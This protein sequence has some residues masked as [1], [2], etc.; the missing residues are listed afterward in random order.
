MLETDD[1]K[2]TIIIRVSQDDLSRTALNI[3]EQ[4]LM[5]INKGKGLKIDYS[6]FLFLFLLEKKEIDCVIIWG[7]K[8]KEKNTVECLALDD[9]ELFG[10]KVFSI[11]NQAGAV[12]DRLAINQLITHTLSTKNSSFEIDLSEMGFSKPKKEKS[13]NKYNQKIWADHIRVMSEYEFEN[14]DIG[15]SIYRDAILKWQNTFFASNP[16]AEN[17]VLQL[18]CSQVKPWISTQSTIVQ[19]AKAY[20]NLCE[21]LMLC[22]DYFPE[23]TSSKNLESVSLKMLDKISDYGN[24]SFDLYSYGM[25]AFF[26]VFYQILNRQEFLKE[27]L[28]VANISQNYFEITALIENI[29]GE[30]IYVNQK[31]SLT[32][33]EEIPHIL[34]AD[35][36]PNNASKEEIFEND[37]AQWVDAGLKANIEKK[38]ILILDITLNNLSDKI[39]Q[40]ILF[41]LNPF[42]LNGQLEIFMIQSLAK[43][44]QLGA[45]N[46]SGGACF[47]L[48][49][50][51]NKD[52]IP[53]FPKPIP[54][55]SVF[56]AHLIGTLQENI[57]EYF[58]QI[59]RNT[60]WMH[61]EL[62]KAFS[63]IVE[64]TPMEI[65]L[66]NK[67]KETK[68][69]CA[70]DVT[71]NVDENTVYV[72][73]GFK[74]FF[75][76]VNKSDKEKERLVVRFQRIILELANI[77]RISIAG[78]Q[79]FGF[80]LSNMSVA[81]DA[82]RFS[83]GVENHQFLRQYVN[84][85]TDFS[86][87]LSQHVANNP[88]KF[89]IKFFE[90][91][92][93]NVY[94]ILQEGKSVAS[95]AKVDLKEERY[96]EHGDEFLDKVGDVNIYFE[97]NALY[98]RIE[99]GLNIEDK[100]KRIEEISQDNIGILGE[101]DSPVRDSWSSIYL[102]RLF[103]YVAIDPES[104][105]V[106]DNS[107][108]RKYK[109]PYSI[110]GF[111]K[112]SYSFESKSQ[113]CDR[114]TGVSIDFEPQFSLTLAGGIRYESKNVLVNIPKFGT[115]PV[116]LDRLRRKE[117]SEVFTKCVRYDLITHISQ[118]DPNSIFL[119]F[120]ERKPWLNY[121]QFI[122]SLYITGGMP[123]VVE[124]LNEK[125]DL[126]NLPLLEEQ[127]WWEHAEKPIDRLCKVL[128]SL[129]DGIATKCCDIS[130]IY[131]YKIPSD[132]ESMR[133]VVPLL[134]FKEQ[135][136]K[137]D[138]LIIADQEGKI[139]KVDNLPMDF[140]SEG[141]EKFFGLPQNKM[142]EFSKEQRHIFLEWLASKTDH[143]ITKL[144]ED[145]MAAI[146][147]IENNKFK[148]LIIEGVFS[149]LGN[150]FL[151]KGVL[152]S[153]VA[154]VFS[155]IFS[156]REFS[157]FI[158]YD[159]FKSWMIEIEKHVRK[160][161]RDS[162]RLQMYIVAI[163]PLIQYFYDT[164]E[165]LCEISFSVPMRN[166]AKKTSSFSFLMDHIVKLE[167]EI[168]KS[169]AKKWKDINRINDYLR[170]YVEY[171]L[172]KKTKNELIKVIKEKPRE[173]LK[174]FAISPNFYYYPLDSFDIN[175]DNNIIDF[176]DHRYVGDLILVKDNQPIIS[177]F[178]ENTGC[179]SILLELLDTEKK[180]DFI[181]GAIRW[182]IITQAPE[183]FDSILNF[184]KQKKEN[185]DKNVR[186][187]LQRYVSHLDRNNLVQ[188]S[189]I[190][191]I[192]F[193]E[194]QKQL[195]IAK[196][197]SGSGT[198]PK[199]SIFSSGTSTTDQSKIMGS[200]VSANVGHANN[201]SK[202]AWNN[203]LQ[204][205]PAFQ[206]TLSTEK[207]RVEKA[208]KDAK[209]LIEE[210]KKKAEIKQTQESEAE[211][212][213]QQRMRMIGGR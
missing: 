186:E 61:R 213:R 32:D 10:E 177:V 6:E 195:L 89:D 119:E 87:G 212:T 65:E 178:F 174:G 73:I 57:V 3:L 134:I 167:N 152:T 78:R 35:I 149:G 106:R 49:Q 170:L 83:I 50:S 11:L 98:L 95:I 137:V 1:R 140:P 183:L 75:N 51:K 181:I 112:Q 92:I 90:K 145:D 13:Y 159:D 161:D 110:G 136:Q 111:L 158:E 28:S 162:E 99:R 102:F 108:G 80:P 175:M 8:R 7:V 202:G 205:Q 139:K 23:L 72:A 107:I 116:R 12:P 166:I 70:T 43:L 113:V 33:I 203:S 45:D 21:I 56:F 66:E 194:I 163:F 109:E 16:Q 47:Y 79:S 133:A 131:D 24:K 138:G 182:A 64:S 169:A 39:L 81:K 60:D 18:L 144:V 30:R 20:Q 105:Y 141:L 204:T 165:H 97:N 199:G 27:Q 171:P 54:I 197:S 122:F 84:L 128:K 206:K 132:L 179:K 26:H 126:N 189:L 129:G 147:M 40:Q 143:T 184:L 14:D 127:S 120:G 191:S 37:I 5:G 155:K 104:I 164:P 38:M 115:K 185:L 76:V 187:N 130:L 22:F 71:L 82:I 15:C 201:V 48:G 36:H 44:I 200:I 173:L 59:R 157:K 192:M 86:F 180:E 29:G 52:D 74:P 154:S 125:I 91:T 121:H 58:L 9:A 100:V 124:Y 94:K 207:E 176:D 188:G 62:R 46:F 196:S 146:L 156:N 209:K 68:Q 93:V 4:R 17:L 150:A 25:S 123:K 172:D 190:E 2:K 117:E 67:K 63:E 160:N 88:K 69:F 101:W 31:K 211:K 148:K 210:E 77:K 96:D 103:F 53:V 118:D 142:M 34:I 85:I 55:K 193:N 168:P 41:K 151:N 114:E 135:Q 208:R 19:W 198:A 153:D 42:I